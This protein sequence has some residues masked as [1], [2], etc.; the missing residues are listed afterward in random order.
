MSQRQD[1]NRRKIY[2]Q[3][4]DQ[5]YGKITEEMAKENSQFLK[6]KPKLF[7]MFLWIRLLSIF[8][9]IK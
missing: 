3:E 9:K 6:K 7:P 1:K 8:V 2:R 4:F 5:K